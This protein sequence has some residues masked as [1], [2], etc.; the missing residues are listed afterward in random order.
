[1]SPQQFQILLALTDEDRHGYGIIRDVADRTAGVVRLGT[2]P[3]Y[4]ALRRLAD[5]GCVRET[6]RRDADDERRRYYTLTPAGRR[7]LQAEAARL[8]TLLGQARR[9]GIRPGAAKARG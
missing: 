1:L 5:I 6:A 7:A 3:L 2:G 4:T 8:E 9:K